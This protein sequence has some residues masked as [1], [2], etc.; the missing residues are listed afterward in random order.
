MLPVPRITLASAFISHSSTL[1]ANTTFEYASAASSEAPRPPS[2]RYSAGPTSS[3]AA[4]NA[5]PSATLITTACSTSA[6]A[7]SLRRAPSARATGGRD[8]AAHGAAGDHLHQHHAREH[9]RHAGQRVRAEAGHPPRLD[10]PGGRLRQ[11]DQHVRPGQPQQGRQDRR[12]Q[13][14]ARAG[15]QGWRT[16]GRPLRESSRVSTS[17]NGVCRRSGRSSLAVAHQLARCRVRRAS[18]PPPPPAGR[19]A[20]PRP[21]R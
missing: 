15:P 3:T 6:S 9:Q 4:E 19:H 17:V 18:H 16:Q 12:L 2:A 5:R 13:Q 21:P 20:P 10:Q 1:P 11:H 14:P 8:A 7:S